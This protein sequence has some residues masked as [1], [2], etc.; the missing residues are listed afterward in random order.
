MHVDSPLARVSAHAAKEMA[1]DFP[2]LFYLHGMDDGTCT[3]DSSYIKYVATYYIAH[4][5]SFT[6][7]VGSHH[8]C[9]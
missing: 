5:Q 3:Q 7:L 9:S 6:S 8:A 4:G 1:L 2:Y